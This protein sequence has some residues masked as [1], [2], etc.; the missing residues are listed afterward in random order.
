[1]SYIAE[2]CLN[3]QI[4]VGAGDNFNA[5][6]AIGMM[7]DLSASDILGFATE[8]ARYYIENGKSYNLG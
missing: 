1:L 6:A 3:P 4:N 8:A 5:G 7:M 2:I